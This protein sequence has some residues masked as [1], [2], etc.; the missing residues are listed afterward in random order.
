MHK[1]FYHGYNSHVLG[2]YFSLVMDSEPEA[3]DICA[4]VANV[5]VVDTSILWNSNRLQMLVE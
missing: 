3:R 1:D 4:P 5:S 2:V